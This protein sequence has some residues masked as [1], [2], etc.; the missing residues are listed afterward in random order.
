MIDAYRK[1]NVD[2]LLNSFEKPVEL[3]ACSLLQVISSDVT[4]E[5]L[6]KAGLSRPQMPSKKQS[7][8]DERPPLTRVSE[9]D[10]DL[11]KADPI[12]DE[13][14]AHGDSDAI[15][16]QYTPSLNARRVSSINRMRRNSGTPG[17]SASMAS[18][19][20]TAALS[21]ERCPWCQGVLESHDEATIGLGI[22]CLATFVHREPSMAAPYLIDMLSTAS[23]IATSTPYSWQKSL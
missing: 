23:R 3:E 7:H 22:A 6:S 18:E 17:I 1:T 10:D 9:I 5:S 11:L 16:H 19:I 20:A 13:D 8:V 14:P 12:A 2:I 15:S 21:T 4:V